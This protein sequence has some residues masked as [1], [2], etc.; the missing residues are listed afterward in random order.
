MKKKYRIKI[1]AALAYEFSPDE[2]KSFDAQ[3]IDKNTYHVLTQNQSLK[4]EI[5]HS[6]FLSRNYTVRLHGKDYEI[7]IANELDVLIDEMGLELKATQ[8]TNELVAPMPGLIMEIIVKEGDKVKE[9]DYVLVLEAM[10]MENALTAPRDGIIKSIAVK[11]EET[12]AK[13][14]LLIE[15]E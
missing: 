13:N 12:V 8:K 14:Q 11:K 10:K 6:D 9:G 1:N 7:T 5:I 15:M 4:A 2:V 3:K